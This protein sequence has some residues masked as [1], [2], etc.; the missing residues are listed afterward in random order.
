MK[1]ACY[2]GTGFMAAWCLRF[3]RF[4]SAA[5]CLLAAAGAWRPAGV[6]AHAPPEVKQIVW[7]APGQG[8]LLIT[9]RGLIFGS[10][11]GDDWRLG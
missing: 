1:P 9:N 5:T 11:D 8:V 3:A 4:L 7:R 10:P 6:R 2:R